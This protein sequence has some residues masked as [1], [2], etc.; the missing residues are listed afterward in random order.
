MADAVICVENGNVYCCESCAKRHGIRYCNNDRAYH[1]E[2]NWYQDP[3]DGYVYAF[4]EN[5]IRAV[6]GLCFVN[7][8][9]ARAYGYKLSDEGKLWVH[10]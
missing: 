6:D 7:E 10:R 9:H 5:T 4:T 3:Y 1:S 8:D 2:G